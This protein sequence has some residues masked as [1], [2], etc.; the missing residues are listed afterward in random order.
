M[1]LRRPAHRVLVSLVLAAIVCVGPA[2]PARAVD[3]KSTINAKFVRFTQA[4]M[5]ITQ[6]CR[7][8]ER[9]GRVTGPCPDEKAT[10]QIEKARG[11]LRRAIDEHCGGDDALC[12]GGGDDVD[13]ATVG[14]NVGHCPNLHAAHCSNTIGHCGDVAECLLC[15]G[16]AAVDQTIDLSYDSLD[17]DPPGEDVA[18]CQATIGRSVARYLTATSEALQRC[19]Q[20]MLGNPTPASCPD[21]VKAMPRMARAEEK[22]FD[23]ICGSCGSSANGCAGD[24][25]PVSWIGFPASCPAVTVPGGP[26]C[27]GP[28]HTLFDLI[29]CVQCVTDFH[30]ACLDPLSVPTLRTYPAACTAP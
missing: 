6:R 18:R 29:D 22:L 24:T 7:E 20:A 3:C 15:V 21:P 23:R 27:A 25:V 4:R 16:E 10:L 26:S 9:V 13:L 5:K 19:E 14:W 8:L 28:V 17:P 11:K 12:G 1:N 2:A 30:T